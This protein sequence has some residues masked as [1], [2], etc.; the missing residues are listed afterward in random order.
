MPAREGPP[1]EKGSV[2][3]LI[4]PLKCQ[5]AGPYEGFACSA[6]SQKRHPISRT[7]RSRSG[8]ESEIIHIQLCVKY[9][10]E[11]R[12]SVIAFLIFEEEGRSY[13][14]WITCQLEVRT[15][16]IP[17]AVEVQFQIRDHF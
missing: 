1:N 17:F 11:V 2:S 14:S 6:L 12:Q 4:L 7:S 3:A 9:E 5:W 13:Y 15:P 10:S 8:P 16:I